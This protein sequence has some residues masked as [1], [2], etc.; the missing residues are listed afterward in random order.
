MLTIQTVETIRRGSR[1]TLF[2][3]IYAILI[4]IIYLCTFKF[5]LKMDFRSIDVVWQVFSKYNPDIT[6]MIIK[7]II[8][9]AVFIIIFGVM[10]VTFSAYILKKK[11]KVAWIILF[12]TGLIFWGLILTLDIMQGNLF[13][14]IP[15]LIGWIMFIIGILLPVRY[16][17]QRD[18]TEY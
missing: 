15:I 10:I 5:L 18:F 14:I 8:L 4:G 11:D 3:G 2:N 7:L 17:L 16:Y 9:K 12:I 6:S 13:T 1:I